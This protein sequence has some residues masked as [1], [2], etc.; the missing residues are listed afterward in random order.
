MNPNPPMRVEKRTPMSPSPSEL[1]EPPECEPPLERLL[2]QPLLLS[3]ELDEPKLEL[4]ELLSLELLELPMERDPPLNVSPPPGR[5]A[6]KTPTDRH[7]RAKAKRT[8]QTRRSR[9]MS[10]V[11]PAI[12]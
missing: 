11:R 2:L 5:A 9:L 1:D 7:A 10:T 4:L 12:R 8:S 3:L 6:A